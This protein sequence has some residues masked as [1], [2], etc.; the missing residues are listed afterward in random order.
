MKVLILLTFLIPVRMTVSAQTVEKYKSI[1]GLSVVNLDS[2][3]VIDQFKGGRGFDGTVLEIS[4]SGRFKKSIFSCN[5]QE[6][7]DSGSWSISKNQLQVGNQKY[8]LFKIEKLRYL[9]E[10]SYEK[11]FIADLRNAIKNA[12]NDSHPQLSLSG[13]IMWAMRI[14]WFFYWQFHLSYQDQAH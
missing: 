3:T 10:T 8:K 5:G 4:S 12:K 14:E 7:F 1:E 13:K 9:V 11:R 2:N 6:P